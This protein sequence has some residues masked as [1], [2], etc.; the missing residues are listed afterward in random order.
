VSEGRLGTQPNAYTYGG[1]SGRLS[2]GLVR[3][4]KLSVDQMPK[5]RLGHLGVV[6]CPRGAQLAAS[7]EAKAMHPRPSAETKTGHEREHRRRRPGCPPRG[8]RVGPPGPGG[9]HRLPA[10]Q[11]HPCR[12]R[13]GRE[14]PGA[15][16]QDPRLMER[17]RPSPSVTRPS[18]PPTR[19]AFRR[20]CGRAVGAHGGRQIRVQASAPLPPSPVAGMRIGHLLQTQR[21]SRPTLLEAAQGGGPTTRPVPLRKLTSAPNARDSAENQCPRLD[22]VLP[23]YAST[24][25]DGST[26]D[27]GPLPALDESRPPPTRVTLSR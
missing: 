27:M 12:A 9:S 13:G 5:G 24:G 21:R 1:L 23:A 26:A 8:V 14:L 20:T 7:T 19:T 11:G 15:D 17:R 6:D 16:R 3:R 4:R 18:S 10:S 2:K 25:V 22:T